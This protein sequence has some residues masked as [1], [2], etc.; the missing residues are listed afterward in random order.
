MTLEWVLDFE[1][2]PD[3]PFGPFSHCHAPFPQ[4]LGSSTSKSLPLSSESYPRATGGPRPALAQKRLHIHNLPWDSLVAH[5]VKNPPTMQETWARFLGWEGPLEKEMATH[6]SILAW[7]IPWTE[8]PGGLFSPQC[9]KESDTTKQLTNG[10][11]R[12][13]S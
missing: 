2:C 6:S 10:L 1:P 11:S 4:I 9:R 8:K 7:R 5:V 3:P 13:G 12:R